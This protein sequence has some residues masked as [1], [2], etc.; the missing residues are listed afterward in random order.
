MDHCLEVFLLQRLRAF[1]FQVKSGHLAKMSYRVL[2]VAERRTLH[3][4]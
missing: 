4:V 2:T 1:D 3:R